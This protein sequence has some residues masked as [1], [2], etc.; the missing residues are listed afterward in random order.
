MG[1]VLGGGDSDSRYKLKRKML[2]DI[3]MNFMLCRYRHFK[4]LLDT[5]LIIEKK[6]KI[7]ANLE[8]TKKWFRNSQKDNFNPSFKQLKRVG[9]P[10]PPAS[11][12]PHVR[13]CE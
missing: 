12:A 1:S 13:L 11:H 8:N 7:T 10:D 3:K 6:G 4:T 2:L 5:L 9:G